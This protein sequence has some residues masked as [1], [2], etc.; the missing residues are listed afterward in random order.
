MQSQIRSYLIIFFIVSAILLFLSVLFFYYFKQY[1]FPLFPW[2]FLFV[3]I[4][5]AFIHISFLRKNNLPPKR[6]INHFMLATTIKLFALLIP[7]A[8]VL[9]VLKNNVIS[10]GVTVLILFF[11]YLA[12]EVYTLM[13]IFKK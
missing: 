12:L 4:L 7:L 11:V 3:A 5:H 2:I 1:Y 8:I 10:V 9:F 13:K 6:F